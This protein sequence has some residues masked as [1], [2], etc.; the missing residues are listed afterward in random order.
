VDQA[1]A[2]NFDQLSNDKQGEY[3]ELRIVRGRLLGRML[4]DH[5][6]TKPY[7]NVVMKGH[8]AAALK[9]LREI[10]GNF[11]LARQELARYRR[12]HG[13][14]SSPNL[15]LPEDLERIAREA[16]LK[17]GSD[18]ISD[19]RLVRQEA[20]LALLGRVDDGDKAYHLGP[21]LG[22]LDPKV[23]AATFGALERE[24]DSLLQS[25]KARAEHDVSA[26][27]ELLADA[28]FRI[29]KTEDGIAK[30]QRFLDE[31]PTSTRFSNITRKIN[32]ELGVERTSRQDDLINYPE[33]GLKQCDYFALYRG[34]EA[35]IHKRIAVKGV[36]GLV[37]TIAE[38]ERACGGHK[39][40]WNNLYSAFAGDAARYGE[41]ELSRE[42]WHKYLDHG[43]SR[44][45]L[46]G[47]QKSQPDCVI[48]P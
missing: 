44:T 45:D 18:S 14:T 28:L 34:F 47:Y 24:V 19:E 30:L 27:L 39:L 12:Q 40:Y 8:E 2:G 31:Y 9:L 17:T 42:L 13:A 22:D 23:W 36:A 41:C 48:F 10:H 21:A 37:E 1:L 46:D 15:R 35:I 25:N 32:V 6:I 4:K 7:P 29:G 43:G 20:E 38:I 5:L 3:L 33:K 16:H 26:A 11:E